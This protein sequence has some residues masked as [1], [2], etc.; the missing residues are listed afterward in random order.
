MGGEGNGGVSATAMPWHGTRAMAVVEVQNSL[1]LRSI[2]SVDRSSHLLKETSFVLRKLFRWY[3]LDLAHGGS[4]NPFSAPENPRERPRDLSSGFG[5]QVG[6]RL[7][8]LVRVGGMIQPTS[9][10]LV[11]GGLAEV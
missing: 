7:W 10:Q 9:P 2:Q 3:T 8:W 1:R 11:I 6:D 5:I 4:S